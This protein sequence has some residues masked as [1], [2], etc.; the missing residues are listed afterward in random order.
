MA[1]QVWI[2]GCEHGRVHV[3]GIEFY[4]YS[5]QTMHRVRALCFL[6]MYIY[7]GYIVHCGTLIGLICK[8]ATRAYIHNISGQV[9]FQKNPFGHQYIDFETI[10]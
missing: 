6:A 3:R 5:L 1:S 9:G 7:Y 10:L 4:N 8:F 2:K